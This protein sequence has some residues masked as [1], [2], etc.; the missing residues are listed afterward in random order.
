MSAKIDVERAT[1]R[2][3]GS[4]LTR[5]SRQEAEDDAQVMVELTAQPDTW[6]ELEAVFQRV[7]VGGNCAAEVGSNRW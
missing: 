5:S 4:D 2:M 7:V 1:R 3:P 6:E